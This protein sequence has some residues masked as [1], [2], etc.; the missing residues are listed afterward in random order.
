MVKSKAK[1]S[2]ID[3]YLRL[4]PNNTSRNIA[5]DPIESTIEFQNPSDGQIGFVNNQR[6]AYEFKFNGI[7]GPE[8]KQDEVRCPPAF[9][10]FLPCLVCVYKPRVFPLSGLSDLYTSL[11]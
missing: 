2:H 9:E 5:W 1:N 7:L 3:I 11:T 8:A 10:W 4:R 6:N